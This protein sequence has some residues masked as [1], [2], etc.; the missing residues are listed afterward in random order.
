MSHRSGSCPQ[1]EAGS[2][3]PLSFK[4][5]C[6]EQ[7]RSSE[8]PA[9]RDRPSLEFKRRSSGPQST[10]VSITSAAQQPVLG[11][12]KSFRL[13]SGHSDGV[14]QLRAWCRLWQTATLSGPGCTHLLRGSRNSVL[15]SPPSGIPEGKRF[16]LSVSTHSF[17]Y[18]PGNRERSWE[19]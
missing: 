6:L 4:W 15:V 18:S 9:C 7:P 2:P 5:T 8:E 14:H 1:Q 17:R 11:S 3:K 10:R 13:G 19:P 16:H 12:G